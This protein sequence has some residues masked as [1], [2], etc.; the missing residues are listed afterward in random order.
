MLSYVAVVF[1]LG[2]YFVFR[3]ELPRLE[4]LP[5]EAWRAKPQSRKS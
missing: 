2:L 4:A 5:S 3:R 1:G